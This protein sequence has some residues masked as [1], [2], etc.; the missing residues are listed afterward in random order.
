MRR[1]AFSHFLPV[2]FQVT[3]SMVRLLS[4]G[5]RFFSQAQQWTCWSVGEIM[6]KLE[7]TN[8]NQE[9]MNGQPRDDSV[10]SLSTNDWSHSAASKITA[11]Q[12]K[13]VCENPSESL[14]MNAIASVT[15][16]NPRPQRW[17]QSG[18]KKRLQVEHRQFYRKFTGYRKSRNRFAEGY[19]QPFTTSD[20]V[21]SD[22]QRS[23]R[24]TQRFLVSAKV[25]PQTMVVII[26]FPKTEPHL[27]RENELLV[28]WVS[29]T[30]TASSSTLLT[31]ITSAEMSRQGGRLLVS[32]REGQYFLSNIWTQTEGEEKEKLFLIER[33]AKKNAFTPTQWKHALKTAQRNKTNIQLGGTREEDLKNEKVFFFI[34]CQREPKLLSLRM[35]SCDHVNLHQRAQK[36]LTRDCRAEN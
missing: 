5:K 14:W 12:N 8:W 6:K 13:L 22:S 17:Q 1:S 30:Q 16:R 11:D 31:E 7:Q 10:H 21:Y 20:S 35:R 36:R 27:I 18:D 19:L 15:T 2:Y 3:S 24:F 34:K 25:F 26:K 9:T 4:S 23:A 32:H 28:V 29:F 33:A